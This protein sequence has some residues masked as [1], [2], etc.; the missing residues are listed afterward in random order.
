MKK[1]GLIRMALLLMLIMSVALFICACGGGSSSSDSGNTDSGSSEDDITLEQYF[2]DHPEDLDDIK[3]GVTED[4]EMQEALQYMDFDV[5]AKGNTLYYDYTFK[6]TYPEDQIE[7][8]SEQLMEGM[9]GMQ[10][11]MTEKIPS[12]ENGYGVKG[13]TVH[14]TY[15]NGDGKVLAE[16]DF[17]E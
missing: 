9:D 3:E 8:I 2:Q 16:R 17:T 15:I 4:E 5:Y 7:S 13:I 6:D 12:I 1:N 14:M 10:E 11:S